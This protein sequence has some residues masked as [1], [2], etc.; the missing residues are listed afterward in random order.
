MMYEKC[1]EMVFS[2]DKT[3][4]MSSCTTSNDAGV[5]EIHIPSVQDSKKRYR[6]HMKLFSLPWWQ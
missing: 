4:Y 1:A 2:L 6:T 3:F 5:H